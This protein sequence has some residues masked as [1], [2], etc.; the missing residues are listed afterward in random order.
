MATIKEYREFFLRHVVVTSGTKPDQ[1]A[2]FPTSYYIGSTLVYNRFLKND[3][4]TEKVYK[5]LYESITF[6]LNKEDTAQL[7]QQGLVKIATDANARDRV[8]NAAGDFVAVVLPHQLPELISL[9]VFGQDSVTSTG[10]ALGITINTVSRTIGGKLRKVY[11]VGV[12][13]GTESSL[14]IDGDGKMQLANDAAAPGNYFYYGTDPAGTKG[15][16]NLAALITSIADDEIAELCPRKFTKQIQSIGDGD[17]VVILGSEIG[18]FIPGAVG[19]G[20]TAQPT[21]DL[22][23]QI[24]AELVGG[25]WTK[26]DNNLSGSNIVTSI[27][28]STG[29]VTITFDIAPSDSPIQ[30]R[31]VMIG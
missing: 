5:K 24:Y 31:V 20:T 22:H 23:I 2:S 18:A 26:V 4:P 16:F 9:L 10:N 15:W 29:D 30:Y 27:N 8:S 3:F 25:V 28:E 1:E 13:I 19:S 7:T 11:Q 6:K 14:E 21:T 12:A 17:A